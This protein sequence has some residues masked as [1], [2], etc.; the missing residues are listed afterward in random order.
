MENENCQNLSSHVTRPPESFWMLEHKSLSSV[1]NYSCTA[2][3]CIN[4]YIFCMF[5]Y[6]YN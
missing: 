6:T 4:Y 5:I 2:H 3:D 1:N